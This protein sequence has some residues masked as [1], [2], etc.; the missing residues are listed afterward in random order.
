MSRLAK[1]SLPQLSEEDLLDSLIEDL[2]LKLEQDLLEPISDIMIPLAFSLMEFYTT[3]SWILKTLVAIGLVFGMGLL[4]NSGPALTP[5]KTQDTPPS[6]AAPSR[7]AV[8]KPDHI[9]LLAGTVAVV[10]AGL[11][12][13]SLGTP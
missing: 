11:L 6:T 5:V 8:L 10:G 4:V 2:K 9:K 12:G 7:L 3:H 1:P 13:L